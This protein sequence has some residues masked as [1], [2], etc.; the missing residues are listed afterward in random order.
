MNVYE[1]DDGEQWWYVA[2]SKDHALKQHIE[3]L[4]RSGTD[5]SDLSKIDDTYL[6]CLIDEMEVKE[7]SPDSILKIIHEDDGLIEKTAAEWAKN[8]AGLIGSTVY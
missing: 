2:E 4:V 6:P 7:W 3:P 8:G 5:I 1:I